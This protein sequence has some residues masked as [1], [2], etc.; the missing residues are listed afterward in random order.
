MAITRLGRV[1]QGPEL[2]DKGKAPTVTSSTTSEAA[3]LRAKEV[4]EQ[5][6]EAFMKV[7]KASEYKVLTAAQVPKETTPDRIE[8]TVSSI[9]SN[10]ISFFEDEIPSEGQG[11]LRAM[12]IVC[13]CN[14]HVV[15]RVMVDNGLALNVCPVST[16]KQMNVDMS[17]IR[18]SKTT[19]RAFDGSRRDVN[20]EINLL[21]D[22]GPCSFSVTF[23][24]L[25]IPN[26]F[27]LLLGRPWIYAAGAVPSSLHQKL[28]FFVEGLDPSIVKHFLSGKLLGFVVSEKGIEVD[29][30]KVKAIME[31]PPP[32]TV[33]EADPLKYLLGSPSSTRNV[34]KWRC[35]LTEYDIEYVSRTS[36]KGQA[37]ANHLA[38]FPIEDDTPINSDFPD[39]RILQAAI[40][41]KVKELKVFGDS[42]LTIF[43]ML[44]QW[45]TKDPKLVP[46]HEYLEELT[47]SFEDISF[48]YTPRMKNQFA[49]AL[50]TLASMRT[51]RR[52]AAHF[53][54]SGETLYRRSFDAILFR[55]VDENEARRLME[56]VHEGNC[57]PHMNGLMLAKK[58]MRLGYFWSTM[59]TDCVNNVRHCHLCQVYAT[60][61]Y[62]TKWI[63]AITLASVTAKAVARFLKRDIIAR[64]GVPATLIADNAKNL[65]NKLVNELCAQFRI[66]HCN[67]SPYRPQM[68]GAVEAANKNIK[69]IIEKMTMNYK[70]WH[71]M[72]Q[73][74][75]VCTLGVSDFYPLIYRGNPVLFGLRHGSSSSNRS[76]DS[77]H[78]GSC[79][80]QTQGSRMG[81]ATL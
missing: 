49:D 19:V 61:D 77:L 60:I 25:E 79:R 2:T 12:H 20:G 55:C 33:H 65:N 57:G 31:L 38:E 43:Q 35:Q 23:Q 10:Q 34:A 50:A 29:L 48:T 73:D 80:V 3:P 1:Y 11:H 24:I 62:F 53:F 9:F 71:E 13:K 36:V 16:L 8:E 69:K 40:D 7:V 27:S 68:N 6:A 30:D 18:A 14:N 15:G 70:N 72:L 74:A 26:A 52:I 41:L 67:S 39:E 51:L 17:Q 47:D 63:E 81:E 76:G 54:L 64:Y 78:E 45:K 42:M 32:S 22:V 66:Q 44:K 5:E 28:K 37:I 56:E 46:Y 21:I 58:L 4:T 59:E 75:P